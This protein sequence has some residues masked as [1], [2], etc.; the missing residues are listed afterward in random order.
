MVG[1]G[2]KQT[3]LG[4]GSLND[5]VH[6]RS[7][8]GLSVGS[9]HRHQLQSVCGIVKEIRGCR[10]QRPPRLFYFNPSHST[11]EFHRPRFFAGNGHS[12][13]S[14]RVFDKRISVHLRAV[15][16]KK[17]RALLDFAR[18]TSHLLDL[19][20]LGGRQNL[21]LHA[22]QQL[23]QFFPH[24]RLGG[25]DRVFPRRVPLGGGLHQFIVPQCHLHPNA[26]A[27]VSAWQFWGPVP[28]I[29]RSA[30]PQAAPSTPPPALDLLQDRCQPKRDP[31]PA[32]DTSW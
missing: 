17:Q 5:G 29:A 27:F 6:E 8:G 32:S 20:A 4:P 1:D 25:L 26:C 19:E 24:L 9:G 12:A 30:S 22:T 28:R 31:G 15:Q 16:R 23:T 3:G 11:R 13:P 18:I 2:A 14:Y 10:H 7:G 21:S